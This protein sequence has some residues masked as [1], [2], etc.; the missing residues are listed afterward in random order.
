VA[1]WGQ[2]CSAYLTNINPFLDEQTVND[3]DFH[4]GQLVIAN[5][6]LYGHALT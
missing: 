6:L 4:I 5:R 3:L 1:C 2:R